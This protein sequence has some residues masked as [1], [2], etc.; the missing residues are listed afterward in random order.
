MAFEE[1]SKEDVQQAL[2]NENVDV[3]NVLPNDFHDK[4]HIKGSKSFPLEEL[5]EHAEEKLSK[6]K[7]YIVYCASH[8]CDA[9]RKAA[10]FLTEKGF[11]AKAY[12]GGIKEW[13]ESGLP[14]EGTTS[15]EEYLAALK[16]KA[17]T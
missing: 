12:E 8:Q 7:Q 15:S 2:E 13:V 14:T 1:A 3:L 6:D 16:E 17:N 11:S 5:K 4:I 10:E 9:S